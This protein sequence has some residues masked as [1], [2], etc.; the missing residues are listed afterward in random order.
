MGDQTKIQWTNHTFNPWLGCQKVSDG[1]KHC[2]AEVDAPARKHRAGGLELWGPPSTAARVRTSESYWKQPFTWDR[3]AASEG[4]R[5]RV[6][7][8]SQAD[9]FEDNAA[10]VAWREQ[11]FSVIERTPHLDW[12]LLTKRPENFKRMLPASWLATPRANVWLGTTVENQAAADARIPELLSTPAA[13]RFLS[14][15]PLLEAI[16]LAGWGSA[17]PA[18]DLATAPNSWSEFAW[19]EWVPTRLRLAIERDWSARGEG[20]K[21][22]LKDHA[23]QRVPASG[24]IVTCKAPE[25]G[26]LRIDKTAPEGVVRGRYLHFWSNIGCVIMDDGSVVHGSAGY[27]SGWLSRWRTDSGL[28]RSKLSWVIVGGESGS[29]ARPFDIAWAR[30]IVAQCK[31]A[32][33]PVFVKQ[34]GA[35]PVDGSI[36]EILGPDLTVHYRRPP[37]D[38]LVAEAKQRPGYMVRPT[39]LQLRD[40]HGGDMS[41][42]P[43]DL[44]VR[45]MPERRDS[46]R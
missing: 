32:G 35:K 17:A 40:S 9:V 25:N 13:V 29:K 22:W 36:L 20:P 27:G 16:D 46:A 30:S 6:F 39:R 3:K 26:Y 31:N 7:C 42:W 34:L 44:R 33:V 14:C 2:Y 18:V 5:H 24:A 38:E 43:E 41:E 23:V 8:A 4:T 12:Q 15:E 45:E 19:P 28:Y 37:E 21:H 1:C 11:L 10:V